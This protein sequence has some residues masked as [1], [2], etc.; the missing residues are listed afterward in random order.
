MKPRI[1]DEKEI[2]LIGCVFYGNPFHSVKG[3]DT[4]NE[5]GKLWTRFNEIMTNYKEYLLELQ[6]NPEYYYEVHVVPKIAKEEKKWY[7]FTGIEVKDIGKM[8]LEMFSKK[9]PKTKYAVFTAKGEDFLKANDYIYNNWLPKSK[10]KES[11]TFQIQLYDSKRYKGLD[12]EESEID[13]YIPIK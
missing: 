11:F 3:W 5:I 8:P 2:H 10:Y 4:A 9:L 6:V 13:F 12:N 7:I 1:I